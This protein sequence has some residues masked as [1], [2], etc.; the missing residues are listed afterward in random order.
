MLGR[1]S[2]NPQRLVP[3]ALRALPSPGRRFFLHG[4]KRFSHYARDR[5]L[6]K[7]SRSPA[8]GFLAAIN[9]VAKH[10]GNRGGSPKKMDLE[11]MSLFFGPRFGVNAPDV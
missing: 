11:S 5:A 10:L 3:L 7:L 9:R 2:R 4:T 1:L 6:L 8:G